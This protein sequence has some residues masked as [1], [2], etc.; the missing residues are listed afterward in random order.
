MKYKIPM[1]N[2]H[3][4]TRK[5]LFFGGAIAL[6]LCAGHN[7]V[8][9]QNNTDLQGYLDQIAEESPSQNTL[10]A[11]QSEMMTDASEG[12]DQPGV[13]GEVFSNVA[14]LVDGEGESETDGEINDALP[15]IS[16]LETR[17]TPQNAGMNLP[18][19][20]DGPLSMNSMGIDIRSP[21]ELEEEIRREAFDAAITGLFPLS[22]DNIKTLLR[23]SEDVKRATEE[24]IDGIPTPQINVETISLD[25][26]VAPMVIKT[27][28]GFITTLNI[29]DVTGAPWP[30]QDVSWAGDY[31]VNEPEEGGHILRI[32]PLKKSAYGNM[33]LRL[34][35]LKTPIIIQL[36]TNLDSVQ[37]R[38]D[39]RVPEYGPF[40]T[41][42]LIEGGSERVAGDSKI[43]SV[44]DGVMPDRAEKLNVSGADS[45]TSAYMMNNVTYV[46]TPLTLISPA[47][48]QSVSSADGMNVYAMRETPVVL[49]SDKGRM[50]RVNL[51]NIDSL[52]RESR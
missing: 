10:N 20:G 47:W 36:E 8:C 29:L 17:Q 39:A 30:I 24:P 23:K 21:E 52:A 16:D 50:V 40:A 33:S 13:F 26:G 19:A 4:Y 45:R 3:Y 51:S 44:L 42:P 25:P 11:Q 35:T 41:T 18:V 7:P 31:E 2:I 22:E 37:Y 49:L 46:R 14:D 48:D 38:V 9:A 1:R 28:A 34:L 6:V 43:M 12:N 32:T 27:A 5:T 15:M